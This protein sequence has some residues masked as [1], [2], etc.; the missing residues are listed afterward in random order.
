[1]GL[2]SLARQFGPIGVRGLF[3][4]AVVGGSVEKTEHDYDRVQR[5]LK[6]IR[7]SGELDWDLIVDPSRACERVATWESPSA[8][9]RAAAVQF[10]LDPW[11]YQP[12]QIQVWCEKEGLASLFAGITDRFRVPLYPGKGFASLSFSREAAL[13]ARQWLDDGK[14]VI[15]LQWG[16]YD[17]S[18]V[19]I[20]DSLVEHYRIHGAQEAEVVRVGLKPEHITRWR[21]PTR[22]TKTSDTRARNFGDDRSVE[23]DAVRPDRLRRWIETEIRQHIEPEPWEQARAEEEAQREELHDFVQRRE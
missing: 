20:S 2:I 3:Y 14:R 8:L 17:P 23:L 18:G 21:L 22:P 1:L 5:L 9:L 12:C 16:D 15:V 6:E 10:R 11:R 19:A 13:E 7:L 4:Q